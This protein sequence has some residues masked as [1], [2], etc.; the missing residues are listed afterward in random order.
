VAGL[1]WS[2]PPQTVWPQGAEAY[3]RAV[4]AGVHGVLQRYQPLIEN[5]MKT[6][7]SWTDRTGNARQTLYAAV[8]PPTV[9][10]VMGVIEFIMSHGVEYGAFLEGLDPRYNFAPTALGRK[11][12]IV[13]PT[14][15]KYAPIIWRDIRAL[16]T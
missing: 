6:S 1:R 11:F 8:E 12:A 14:L 4:R 5:E 3:A 16:F 15:D 9:A 10:E 13:L 7:A 2:A